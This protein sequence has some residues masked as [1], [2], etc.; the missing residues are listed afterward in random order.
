MNPNQSRKTVFSRRP[1]VIIPRLTILP[2]FAVKAA[3]CTS[4][5][6][7]SG[8]NRRTPGTHAAENQ[9]TSLASTQSAGEPPAWGK[10]SQLTDG[11]RGH[12]E[13][14]AYHKLRFLNIPL[15]CVGSFHTS[16][17]DF[18]VSK[19]SGKLR[20]GEMFR[21]SDGTRE[22]ADLWASNTVANYLLHRPRQAAQA[23]CRATYVCD[24]RGKFGACILGSAPKQA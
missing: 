2:H 8:L 19:V 23:G 4:S 6:H 11:S 17:C 20:N 14:N 5:Q 1:N 24:K 21:R 16:T 22:R 18:R 9:V 3:E 15:L 7:Y 10:I 13:G 12:Y